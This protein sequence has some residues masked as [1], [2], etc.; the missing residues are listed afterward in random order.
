MGLCVLGVGSRR[1]DLRK[2]ANRKWEVQESL[3]K[4]SGL[5]PGGGVGGSSCCLLDWCQVLRFAGITF[6]KEVKMRPLTFK[7]GTLFRWRA[8]HR[9]LEAPHLADLEA[10]YTS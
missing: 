7:K 3:E 5:G 6:P 1:E 9:F 8:V 10:V 2:E 4:G